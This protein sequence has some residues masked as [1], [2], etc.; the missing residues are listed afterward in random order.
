MRTS[1]SG[2]Y[3]KFLLVLTAVTLLAGTASAIVAGAGYT[4][5]D[6]VV[7]GCLDSPNGVNC[8]NYVDKKDVYMSGG[9]VKAGL[10]DGDYFFAVI[11]PGFQ[12]GG[13]IDGAN[14]NLSDTTAGGTAGDNG[15]GDAVSNRIFTVASHEISY[16]GTHLLGTSPSGKPI[17]ALFPYD[18]TPNPGGVYILAVCAVGATGP[19][20]CKYDAFRISAN[21]GQCTQDCGGTATL[22]VCKFWDEDID[23]VLNNEPLL[24]NWPFTAANVDGFGTSVTQNT[25]NTVADGVPATD[26]GCTTFAITIPV[27]SPSVDVTL[28]EGNLPGDGSQYCSHDGC[29]LPTPNPTGPWTQTA[30][31]DFINNVVLTS[32][33]VTV[34]P[35]DIKTA[36]PFG[37]FTGFDLTVKKDATPS[38][39]R[40]YNWEIGKAVDKTEIDTTSGGSAPF[41]YTVN[42]NEAGFA[43]SA[44]QVTGKITVTNPNGFDVSGIT[45]TDDDT[46]DGGSCTVTG[47]TNVT[48]PAN[49]STPLSYTCTYTGNPGSGTNTAKAAWDATKFSTPDGSA[50]GT[51]PFTFGAPTNLVNKTITV[52]DTFNGTL[53]TLGT[54]AATDT[55]PYTTAAYSYPHTVT[56]PAGTCSTYNNKAQITETSQA[57]SQT[58]K[59]CGASDLKVSK[60]AIAAYNSNITKSVDKT[61]V[62]QAGGTVTFNYT[63]KVT[64]SGWNVTGGTNG[65]ITVTNPNDWEEI[66]ASV[67]DFLS[68]S[69]GSCTVTGGS[70]VTIPRSS[71][72]T[73][74]YSCTFNAVPSASSGTNTGTASWSASTYFTA[75]GS[76]SGTAPYAFSP[77]TITDCFAKSGVT[78]TSNPLGTVTIPPGSATFTYQRVVNNAPGGTCQEYD[79]TATITQTG[80]TANA[81]ATVCNTKTGALTMGFWQNKN[82]QGIISGGGASTGGVCY[83]GTWLEQYAPFQDLSATATCSQVAT[84]VYNVI[85]AANASGASMNA[86]LK[87]QM[88]ATA[89]D[90]YF[91][92]P[93]LGGNVIGA[94]TPLGGVKIDL[95]QVCLMIDGS[96]GTATCSGTF[97]ITSNAFGGATSGTVSLLLTYA[98][99]QSN[100]GGSVWYGQVKVIQGLAKNTF[101]AIN[102]QVAYIAP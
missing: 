38:F 79:N 72:V 32:E 9:P 59:V 2:T 1:T 53:T 15:S 34:A 92:T 26:L 98:A 49:G 4:T 25:T 43:D 7:G 99:S 33:K 87:A 46:P 96:G 71:S 74:P 14:G 16:S 76:A 44:W 88:L 31:Y 69:G 75:D 93:G 101:D 11:A 61:K 6:A 35:G 66:T 58:V 81:A 3:T 102:N 10:S 60:T 78:C 97:E 47:G 24:G 84:Y 42:V 17:I 48:V 20:Q 94:P 63:V 80:M 39:T 45:V 77:L 13:F 5:F 83:S 95:T 100:P 12:N 19:S 70:S 86:M 8:N 18:D 23:H 91:S 56:A 28:T 55:T 67:G 68:D 37:N 21:G 65:G 27:G 51:A 89:L 30:P 29:P 54:L 40:T 90:V 73:L 62:E 82:G 41:N 22:T 57:S 85:K 50:T 52:T 64:T 36:D